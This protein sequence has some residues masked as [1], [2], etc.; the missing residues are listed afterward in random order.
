MATRVDECSRLLVRHQWVREQGIPRVSTLVGDVDAARRRWRA[1]TS[2][3]G[4]NP[5]SAPIRSEP[6]RA[7]SEWLALTA[8]IAAQ[9]ATREPRAPIAIAVSR[10]TFTVWHGSRE[11]RVKAL[12]DEGLV[13]VPRRRGGVAK[14]ESAKTRHLRARSLAELTLFEA[15]QSTP[16]TSGRFRLNECLPFHFGSRA[17]EID[18]VSREDALAIEIDGYHHFA[19]PDAYRRDRRKDLLVQTHGFVV[20]R[21]LAEDVLADPRVAVSAVVE[22]LGRRAFHERETIR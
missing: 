4:R 15:L 17:V 13:H 10:E 14:R 18:L 2:A 1:W 5:E 12:I 16:S 22:A 3:G 19:D 20:L 21:F 8:T 6:A 11:S 9:Q 7:G